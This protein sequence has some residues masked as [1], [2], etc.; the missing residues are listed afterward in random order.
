MIKIFCL[1]ICIKSEQVIVSNT[2]FPSQAYLQPLNP[3]AGNS[4]YTPEELLHVLF[5]LTVLDP[6]DFL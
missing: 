1:F 4:V 6:H 3:T 5:Q 2:N